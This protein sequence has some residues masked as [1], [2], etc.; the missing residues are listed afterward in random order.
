MTTFATT[1]A[2][3]ATT[4]SPV[5][6]SRQRNWFRSWWSP[7]S[8]KQLPGEGRWAPTSRS[9]SV[10]SWSRSRN[11]VANRRTK[12][13]T[14]GSIPLIFAR[15]RPATDPYPRRRA[16]PPPSPHLCASLMSRVFP[17]NRLKVAPPI[18]GPC[19]DI[20]R[21]SGEFACCRK[22]GPSRRGCR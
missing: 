4:C 22:C 17:A 12:S 1:I 19:F 15:P 20:T 10:A 5:A 6:G 3:L 16:V 18:S 8:T 11:R 13:R 14:Q 7:H 21:L 9:L 2:K